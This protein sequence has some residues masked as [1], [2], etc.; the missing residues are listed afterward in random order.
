MKSC[1]QACA[2]N[3][4]VLSLPRKFT[5]KNCKKPKGFSCAPFKNCLFS[6]YKNKS[7]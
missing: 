4:K 2:R 3:K 1:C 6:R 5:K 7:K